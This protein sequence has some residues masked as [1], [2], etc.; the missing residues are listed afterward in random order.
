[1]FGAVYH[2]FGAPRD[3]LKKMELP[4]PQAGPGQ[5]RVKTLLSVIHNHDLITI[6]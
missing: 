2:A 4:A 5:V 6:Q 1:M 3:V